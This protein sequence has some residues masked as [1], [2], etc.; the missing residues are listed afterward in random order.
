MSA[1]KKAILDS[2]E[3]LLWEKG[4]SATSPKM[5]QKE[6]GTGQGSMYHHFEGKPDLAVQTLAVVLDRKLKRLRKSIFVPTDTAQDQLYTF[7]NRPKK[8]IDG[9]QIGRMAYDA[10]AMVIGEIKA[11]IT[12]YF[13]TL[14]GHIMACLQSLP[15]Y[16][17]KS[18]ED[19]NNTAWTIIASVQGAFL[20]ARA[21]K[22]PELYDNAVNGLWDLLFGKKEA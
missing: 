17:D 6:S 10:D 14:H 11:S 13:D 1:T 22:K 21:Y 15:Q 5:I 8:K 20:L 7:L 9:C 16:K 12:E 4:Y 19:N 3:T 18:D 2:A